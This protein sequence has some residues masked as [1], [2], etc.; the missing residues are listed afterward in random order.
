MSSLL[1]QFCCVRA[2][3]I[4]LYM[5]S[6]RC[7]TKD[8]TGFSQWDAVWSTI[9]KKTIFTTVNQWRS[10][11]IATGG[12]FTY[13]GGPWPL[14]WQKFRRGGHGPLFGKIANFE[15]SKVEILTCGYEIFKNF[16]LRA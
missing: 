8:C 3:Q 14:I 4:S 7:P 10:R 2:Q 1:R 13:F 9:V 6:V 11:V 12:S 5:A 15:N 16:P